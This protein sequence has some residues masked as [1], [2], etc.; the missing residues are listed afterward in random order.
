MIFV[1][2]VFRSGC[3]CNSSFLFFLRCLKY[4][5]FHK[6]STANASA[7]PMIKNIKLFILLFC[8]SYCSSS[9]FDKA[10]SFVRI[11]SLYISVMYSCATSTC[12]FV[13]LRS[14]MYL[15][16]ISPV[17]VRWRGNCCRSSVLLLESKGRKPAENQ[18]C[19]PGVVRHA[20]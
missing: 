3:S 14:F 10:K 6:K 19:I 18:S 16:V 8:T 20:V 4:C 7:N 9:G 11:H 15:P 12:P 1:A 2:L 17:D 13:N 5:K